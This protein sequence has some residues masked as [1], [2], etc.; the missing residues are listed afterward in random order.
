MRA[1]TIAYESCGKGDE[2]EKKNPDKGRIRCLRLRQSLQE[3]R[4]EDEKK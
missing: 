1:I 3:E 2:T 4:E